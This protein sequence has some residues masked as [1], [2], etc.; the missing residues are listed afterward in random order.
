M[1]QQQ[2]GTQ[3]GGFPMWRLVGEIFRLGVLQLGFLR[4][5]VRR[6]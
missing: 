6:L 4:T 5:Y 2:D 1:W 3:A